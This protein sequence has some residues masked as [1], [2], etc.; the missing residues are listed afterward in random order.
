VL[1][2]SQQS[3]EQTYLKSGKFNYLNYLDSLNINVMR[4][5]L[6]TISELLSRLNNPQKSYKTILVAGTNGKGSTATMIASILQSAGYRVGLYTSP[7]LVDVRERITVNGKKISR[8]DID[9]IIDY[10]K[11][12]KNNPLTYF[13]YL[14][15]AAFLYFKRK[16]VDIAVLEVGLGGRLDA[17]NVCKPLVSVIT[18]V[19]LEH[20]AYLGKTL[21]SIAYEK[22]DI[23]KPRGVC[24]TA[25]KQKKVLEVFKNICR[26]RKAKL[27]QI[28]RDFRIIK[29]S[30]KTFDYLGLSRNLKSLCLGMLEE[31]QMENAALAI[32]AVG[33]VAKKGLP[34]KEQAIRDGLKKAKL[35][36][37]M[38]VLQKSPLFILDGAHNPGGIRALCKTLKN[39]YTYRRLILIFA[40]LKDKKYFQMLHKIAPLAYKIILPRLTAA[41]AEHPDNIIKIIHKIGYKAQV[42]GSVYR[43]IKIARVLAAKDDLI[44]AAGSLY[45]A[46]EIKQKFPKNRFL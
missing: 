46:A 12:K 33:I 35:P 45:L 8:T 25:A 16:K 36:A 41:R 1:V 21:S 11:N 27:Y 2:T 22:G 23:V 19:S 15:A 26:E 29:N 4:L 5:G 3:G 43:A 31:H 10:I 17:T 14:T 34:V 40:C 9:R 37:R 6:E 24:V 30:D 13:E 42:A 32:T 39:E 44:L 38:E 7:H 28:G 20:T 18:N